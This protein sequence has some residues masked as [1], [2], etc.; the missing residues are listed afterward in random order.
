MTQPFQGSEFPDAP[1]RF[2]CLSRISS[3]GFLGS[4]LTPVGGTV[5]RL[6]KFTA[7]GWLGY[8]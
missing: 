7:A 8:H 3:A 6:A 5:A 4:R 1:E 2:R